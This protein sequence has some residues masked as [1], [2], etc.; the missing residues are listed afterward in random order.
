MFRNICLSFTM[1]ITIVFLASA[2]TAPSRVKDTV[3]IEKVVSAKEVDKDAYVY[4]LKKRIKG[5]KDKHIF[6]P[7]VEVDKTLS[8]YLHDGYFVKKV[9]K[10][11]TWE[12][13]REIFNKILD[14][15][16]NIAL[17][18]A[19]DLVTE[20]IAKDKENN[21]EGESKS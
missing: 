5:E 20:L 10:L 12:K 15:I 11:S 13:R 1:L 2:Q 9:I 21:S 18:I 6:N 4:I 14:G 7:L 3:K 8:D 16:V 17:D 19:K